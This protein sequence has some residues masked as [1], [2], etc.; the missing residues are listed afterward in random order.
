MQGHINQKI[1]DVELPD[2]QQRQGRFAYMLYQNVQ[3]VGVIIKQLRLDVQQGKKLK[4]LHGKTGPKK[5]KIE[6]RGKLQL[7]AMMEMM[8]G[9]VCRN[10]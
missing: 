9:M 1:I 6:R 8:K 2:A 4:Q 3:I 5:P 7:N 10:G